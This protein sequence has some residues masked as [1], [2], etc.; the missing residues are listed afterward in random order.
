MYK[1]LLV[2][3]LM[4]I[5]GAIGG[6]FFKK[7]ADTGESIIKILFT[8]F[9][10][11]GGFFYVLGALL[12]I[13]VLKKLNYTVVLPITAITYV[14]TLTIAYF[15]LKEKLSTRKIAGL[16]LIITGALMLGLM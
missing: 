4:T 8:P 12:N 7:A 3:L 15:V 5:C 14:W 6:F 2:C 16:V 9:L 11:I 10:Y 13:W 1:Y